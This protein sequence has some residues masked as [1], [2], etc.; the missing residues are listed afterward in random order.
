MPEES[1]TPDLVSLT[2]RAFAASNG[3]DFDAMMSFLDPTCVW[4]VS[5]WGLGTRAGVAEIRKFI[6]GWIGSFDEQRVVVEEMVDLGNGVVFAVASQHAHSAG[7]RSHL[8]LT[9]ATVFVWAKGAVVRLTLD[10]DIGE[11]RAAAE[12]LAEERG[13]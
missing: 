11:A 10:R 5:S 12:R 13:K 9:S 8:R 4:D 1:T 7:S 6:E 3:D 2:R